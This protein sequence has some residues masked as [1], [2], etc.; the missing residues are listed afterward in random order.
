TAI[1]EENSSTFAFSIVADRSVGTIARRNVINAPERPDGTGVRIGFETGGDGTLVENNW[2][3]GINQFLANTDGYG[4][5]SCLMRN[6]YYEN[7]RNASAGRGLTQIN[8]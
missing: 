1:K 7:T 3:Y 6:N 2:V 5:T 8:N 4:T